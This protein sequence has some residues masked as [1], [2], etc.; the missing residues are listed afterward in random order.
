ML[1]GALGITI[2]VAL[3]LILSAAGLFAL[4]SVS[5]ARR[6]REIGV[7][8][9]LGASRTGVLKAVF[10]RSAAQLGIGI[11]LGNVLVA[12]LV[13]AIGEVDSKTVVALLGISALMAAVGALASAVP[14]WRAPQVQPTE[15]LEEPA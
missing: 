15:V 3:A 8:A 5:V 13:M 9:A 12:G 4:M 6:S 1:M 2:V 10:A 7:R 14:A 11:L